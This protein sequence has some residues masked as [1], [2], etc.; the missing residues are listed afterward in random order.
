MLKKQKIKTMHTQCSSCSR[1]LCPPTK[2]IDDHFTFSA[3]VQVIQPIL[4]MARA[5]PANTT[6]K[7]LDSG[8][9]IE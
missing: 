5:S 1:T 7:I 2:K 4:P 9:E 8:D 3:V 6:Q